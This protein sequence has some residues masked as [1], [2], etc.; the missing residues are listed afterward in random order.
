MSPK[1]SQSFHPLQHTAN[2]YSKDFSSDSD[3][4]PWCAHSQLSIYSAFLVTFEKLILPIKSSRSGITVYSQHFYSLCFV[5]DYYITFLTYLGKVCIFFFFVYGVQV[6]QSLDR[7]QLVFSPE[8]F[9][10]VWIPILIRNRNE[11]A[12][13]KR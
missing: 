10:E 12:R 11:R 2:S 6:L 8:T 1:C 3:S 4:V 7:H 13:R 5:V 9:L